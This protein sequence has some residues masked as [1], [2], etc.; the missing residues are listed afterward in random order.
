MYI[1]DGEITKLGKFA[2]NL[3]CEPENAVLLWYAFTRKRKKIEVAHPD[4]DMHSLV[5]VWHYCQWLD[6]EPLPWPKKKKN[7]FGQRDT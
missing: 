4:G 1:Q 3:G 2:L 6:A 5:S 7:G